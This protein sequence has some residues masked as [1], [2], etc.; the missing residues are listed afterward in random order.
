MST[1][2]HFSSEEMI[3]LRFISHLILPINDDAKD[4]DVK[5]NAPVLHPY[6][7]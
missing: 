7:L 6:R 4:C 3:P 2:L 5:K 1:F